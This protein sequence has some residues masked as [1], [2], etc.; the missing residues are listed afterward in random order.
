MQY[1][2][3]S[4]GFKSFILLSRIK[5]IFTHSFSHIRPYKTDFS[6]YMVCP[7]QED[8]IHE[9]APPQ[10][11]RDTV[12]R[13]IIQTPIPRTSQS[14]IYLHNLVRPHITKVTPRGCSS[15]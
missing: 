15:T 7:F 10:G 3:I 9:E 6:L 14:Q 5:P 1:A 8:P 2:S 12:H 13:Q 11:A 4:C